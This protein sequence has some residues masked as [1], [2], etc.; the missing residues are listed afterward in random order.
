[1]SLIC[2]SEIFKTAHSKSCFDYNQVYTNVFLGKNN[3]KK[4]LN[5]LNKNLYLFI[6]HGERIIYLP[7][8]RVESHLI[9]RQNLNEEKRNPRLPGFYFQT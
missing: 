2:K 7:R 8:P 4:S 5:L 1:M 3:T 6:F 9:S